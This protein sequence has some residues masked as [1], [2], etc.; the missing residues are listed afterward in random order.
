MMGT[1][2]EY[3]GDTM[4]VEWGTQRGC[5]GDTMGMQ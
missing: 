3:N 5:D 1:K 2:W 4:T